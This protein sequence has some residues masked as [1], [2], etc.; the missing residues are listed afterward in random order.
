MDPPRICG[1]VQ[2]K[3][4]ASLA[5]QACRDLRQQRHQTCTGPSARSLSMVSMT[6]GLLAW[7]QQRRACRSARRAS[8]V[9]QTAPLFE[10]EPAT[11]EGWS[12]KMGIVP[13]DDIR[14]RI[15]LT[16]GML[17]RDILAYLGDTVWEYMVLRHQYQQVVRSPFTESQEVRT[18]RQGRAAVMLHRSGALTG[19][20][21]EVLLEGAQKVWLQKVRWNFEGI[22]QVGIN[23]YCCALGL[24]TLLG[25]AYMDAASSD[26][27]LTRIINEIGLLQKPGMED[28]MLAEI[29]GGIFD[30][31]LR[32]PGN[33]FLALAP[34]GHAALRLYVSRY[35]CERPLV[36]SEFIYRVKLALRQEE[37]DAASI[38]FLRDSATA[39]EAS[40]MQGARERGDSYAF[41]FECLLGH[42]ALNLP[43]RLHQIVSEFGWAR[44][45]EGT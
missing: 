37:L 19:R 33:Y 3:A 22:R 6:A 24:R 15:R 43:Y 27:D 36:A 20:E 30:P 25:Y 16:R 12:S 2:P 18:I 29:T 23:M 44:P 1:H 10:V 32:P 8:E 4:T 40:L 9:M 21:R 5:V 28:Q 14:R 34:L 45:L 35:L 42:L 7:R 39:E 38:A 41:A 11:P 13:P 26:K 17:E 31:S